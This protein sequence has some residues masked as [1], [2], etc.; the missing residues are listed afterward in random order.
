M[1]PSDEDIAQASEE[2]RAL[3]I[4]LNAHI[5]YVHTAWANLELAL[6]TLFSAI[7]RIKIAEA[8]V[9]LG[10][11]AANRPKRDLMQNCANLSLTSDAKL[12]MVERI[13]RRTTKA[14][15]KRNF[16]AH[17]M[18]GHHQKHPDRITVSGVSADLQPALRHYLS[19]RK[20]DLL[21]LRD[22][23]RA[24]ASDAEKIAPTIWR[25]R[26]RPLPQT[27]LR[28]LDAHPVGMDNPRQPPDE[29]PPPQPQPSDG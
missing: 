9:I 8:Q 21:D 25:A 1:V 5:A 7:L 23:I 4:D 14:A 18:A 16:L 13:L 6:A 28:T 2:Q 26:R 24:I 12:K 19:Y 15:S 22:T 10:S 29:T 20:K 11:L 17:G 27:P 3:W